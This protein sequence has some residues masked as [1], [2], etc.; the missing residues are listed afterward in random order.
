MIENTS[1][2]LQLNW[3]SSIEIVTKYFLSLLFVTIMLH[4][5]VL[6]ENSKL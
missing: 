4:K 5:I 2:I 1:R 3:N 6:I